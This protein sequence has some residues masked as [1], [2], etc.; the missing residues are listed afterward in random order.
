VS[1]TTPALVLVATPIGNLA[2][3]SPRAIEA[4][5]SADVIACEDTRRTRALLTHAG[6]SGAGKLRAVHAANESAEAARIVDEIRSGRRVAYASDAGT[7]GISD[8][9]ARLVRACLDAGLPVETVPGPS[10]A[11]AALVVSGLSTDRF[12][13]EG[14][15]PRK[16]GGRAERIAAIAA[17]GVTTII[18]EA[19]NRIAHT[20]SD[21]TA[22][23]GP[24]R[25][26]AIARELTKVYEEVVRGSLAEVEQRIEASTPRGEYV[27]VLEGASED[28]PVEE[29]DLE[30][31]VD[32]A[33][34]RGLSSRDASNEVAG[35]LGVSKRRAY[36][37]TLRR[38][39]R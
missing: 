14:F 29:A 2:D 26:V 11:I 34:G 27:I 21:L 28:P 5:E 22:A 20:V 19:P 36:E 16:G 25:R 30:E 33:L 6:V 38:R 24:D 31:A 39:E 17:A 1:E 13:F 9:G 37:A 10:A 23:C 3:L 32:A 18:Y 35:A 4:L 7:P 15:L 8:P 12:V